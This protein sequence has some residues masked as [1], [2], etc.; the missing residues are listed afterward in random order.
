MKMP[1]RTTR[2][3]QPLAAL[4]LLLLGWA[5]ARTALWAAEEAHLAALPRA[6]AH[7]RP[8]PVLHRSLSAPIEAPLPQEEGAPPVIIM[9]LDPSAKPITTVPQQRFSLRVAAGHQLLYFAAVSASVLPENA[10]AQAPLPIPPV[11][12][13]AS[14]PQPLRRWSGDGWVMQR[15][16]GS[17][18][19][20]AASLPGQSGASSGAYGASQAGVVLRY[21]LSAAS[22]HQP[23][24]YLRATTAPNLPRSAELAAG[25]ALRPIGRLPAAVMAEARLVDGAGRA[26]IRPAVAVVSLAPP[27]ALPLGLRGESYGQAGWVGGRDQTAFV[28]GQVRIDSAVWRAGQAELRLGA[29][30]WGGAQRGASRLDLGPG[31]TLSVPLGGVNARVAADYR[32]RVAG[33]AA[34]GSGLAVTFSAGF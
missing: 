1:P 31:A 29:G 23:A 17:G 19:A 13:G 4:A 20:L 33:N 2:R 22:P 14:R 5:G 25:L 30:A 3:G 24:L 16:G 18:F 34:P 7:P 9:P 26:Y 21:R 10:R 32:L 11:P 15:Q 12:L 27:V 28:D 6:A 8:E